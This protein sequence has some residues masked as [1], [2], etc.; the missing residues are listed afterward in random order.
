MEKASRV[1]YTIANIFNWIMVVECVVMIVL[2]ILSMTNVINVAEFK[3][4]DIGTLIV[5]IYLLVVSL[6]A[7]TMVGIAK[8]KN[9]SKGWD[10]LFIILGVIGGNI[11]Y[12][13]G[14]I[15]GLVAVR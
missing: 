6:L 15:F 13:L 12:T 10:I 11:F 3:Q 4:Y 1:M 7:I 14:G 9:S 5:F 2:S 8:A